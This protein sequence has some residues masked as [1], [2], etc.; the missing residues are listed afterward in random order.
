[1][2]FASPSVTEKSFLA[3]SAALK[4]VLAFL[5]MPASTLHAAI[6]T[7]V[8]PTYSTYGNH[9]GL[10]LLKI[11]DGMSLV[12]AIY[13][14]DAGAEFEFVSQKVYEDYASI[15]MTC[16]REMSVLVFTKLERLYAPEITI[17][18]EGNTVEGWSNDML[19]YNVLATNDEETNDTVYTLYGMETDGCISG[20]FVYTCVEGENTL[21][22]EHDAADPGSLY[23][24]QII[25]MG[26]YP[27]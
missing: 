23:Y 11:E 27:I 7:D 12:E 26:M 21:T 20:A 9:G 5:G 4:R 15:T 24:S 18:E 1:M 17:P 6:P 10:G 16:D 19:A 22:I 8:M 3:D 25:I 14:L 2:S 13:N